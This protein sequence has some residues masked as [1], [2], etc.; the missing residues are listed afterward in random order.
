MDSSYDK[1]Y[2]L[3]A[4]LYNGAHFIAARIAFIIRYDVLWLQV[5]TVLLEEQDR[6]VWL[7]IPGQRA[8]GVTREI[9][10][11]RD[12]RAERG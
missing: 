11:A 7:V 10:E 6:L 9:L 2:T 3:S 8:L 5:V 4:C 12:Q 1:N